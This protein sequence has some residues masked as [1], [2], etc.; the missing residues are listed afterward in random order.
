MSGDCLVCCINDKLMQFIVIKPFDYV[1][2]KCGFFRTPENG[3]NIYSSKCVGF[4]VPIPN[5][6]CIIV[7][8]VT[9]KYTIG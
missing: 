6:C 8:D 7:L 3:F 9:H 1:S 2:L 4:I 5:F